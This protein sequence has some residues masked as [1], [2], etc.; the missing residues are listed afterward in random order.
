M[1]RSRLLDSERFM[2]ALFFA[3]SFNGEDEDDR[4]EVKQLEGPA[5][6]SPQGG[7]F[8]IIALYKHHTRQGPRER[9]DLDG[10]SRTTCTSTCI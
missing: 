9:T 5:V 7:K 2:N 8:C 1:S 4:E 3:D 10:P 6:L